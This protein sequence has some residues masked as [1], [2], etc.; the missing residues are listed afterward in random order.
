MA[1]TASVEGVAAE[2]LGDSRRGSGCGG[3]GPEEVRR[4]VEDVLGV[5]DTVEHPLVAGLVG[6]VQCVVDDMH[7]D[8][9]RKAVFQRCAVS[10][11]RG[12]RGWSVSFDCVVGGPSTR[13]GCCV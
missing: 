12:H 4:G 3:V 9:V 8:L 2:A 11:V 7:G 6:V 13:L 5:R 1:A 10:A